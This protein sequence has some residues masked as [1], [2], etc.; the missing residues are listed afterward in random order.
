MK[1]LKDFFWGLIMIPIELL[2]SGLL[3][4][5]FWNWFVILIFDLPELNL[6]KAIGLSLV[7]ALFT[8]KLNKEDK[9]MKEITEL[10]IKKIVILFVFLLEGWIVTLFM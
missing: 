8:M 4:L 3:V 7:V 5:K 6:A 10:F 2:I 9:D 1:T